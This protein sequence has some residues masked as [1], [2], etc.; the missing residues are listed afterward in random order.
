MREPHTVTGRDPQLS[1]LDAL[2]FPEPGDQM[3]LSRVRE[4]QAPTEFVP[5]F[6]LKLVRAQYIPLKERC[7]IRS[8]RDV[9]NLVGKILDESDR[10]QM[11]A[12]LMDTKN[13]VIGLNGPEQT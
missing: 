2:V 1:F 9:A 6:G 10:E 5:V 13:G 11:I 3:P 8:P 12:V 4:A 7:K